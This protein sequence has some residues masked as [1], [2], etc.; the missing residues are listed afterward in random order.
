MP[1]KLVLYLLWES[2]HTFMCLEINLQSAAQEPSWE[3]CIHVS[4][5]S[6][7]ASIFPTLQCGKTK[8]RFDIFCYEEELLLKSFGSYSDSPLSDFASLI[9]SGLQRW[10]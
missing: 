8:G 3:I 4:G 2:K 1:V 10:E 5:R 9:H 7:A 6:Q